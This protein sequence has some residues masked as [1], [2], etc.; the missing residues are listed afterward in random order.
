VTN[1]LRNMLDILI[2]RTGINVNAFAMARQID[3]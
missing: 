2:E 1:L 3:A